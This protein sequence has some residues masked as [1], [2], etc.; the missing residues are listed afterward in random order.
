MFLCLCYYYVI[1]L[2]CLWRISLTKW[3]LEYVRSLRE[4]ESSANA[5]NPSRTHLYSFCISYLLKRDILKNIT[6]WS[7]N[8]SKNQIGET[9]RDMIDIL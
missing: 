5:P 8:M 3:K 4:T 6:G 1:M 2:L 7:A 9:H